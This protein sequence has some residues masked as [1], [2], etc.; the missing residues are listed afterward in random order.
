MS[1]NFGTQ[2]GRRASRTFIVMG[3]LWIV[4]AAGLYVFLGNVPEAGGTITFLVVL[5]GLIGV[6]M[7]GAALVIGRATAGTERIAT[8]GQLGSARIVSLTQTGMSLN[9]QPQIGMELDVSVL[10]M[11]P[12]RTV[13][14][15]FVPFLYLARLQP[16]ATLA[17]RVDP[18][19][20]K[21]VVV[22]WNEQPPSSGSA[23]DGGFGVTPSA[24]FGAG[25]GGSSESLAE[26]A[27]ALQA[28]GLA[29]P[30]GAAAPFAS[31]D[32]AMY[33]VDQ[34]RQ[35]LRQNG[36]P[37]T[38]R[39]D[40]LEDSGQ[41]IGSDRLMSM[42]TTITIPGRPPVTSPLSAAMVPI[43][44]VGR[45]AVGV[46]LPVLVAPDNPDLSMFEWDKI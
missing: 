36:I 20:P 25:G 15:E 1:Q 46:S 7:I 42:Q 43:A 44:K 38:A 22:A 45:V 9:D 4:I 18:A 19:Q 29:G 27:A 41:T 23:P 28:R 13:H 5:F 35:W 26:V 10:G 37:G 39:I 6:I 24:G 34:L 31:P 17:V 30:G 14:K 32:Q 2:M 40:R 11:S 3:L 8:Q 33:S 16:G 12:Y 21:K